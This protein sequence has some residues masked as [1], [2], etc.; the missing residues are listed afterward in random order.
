MKFISLSTYF[1]PNRF[2][3]PV[4]ENKGNFWNIKKFFVIQYLFIYS[5]LPHRHR[6]WYAVENIS[7]GIMIR[8][9]SSAT[10]V[11][12][13]HRSIESFNMGKNLMVLL[14]LQF[15]TAKL[16]TILHGA[17]A[18]SIRDAWNVPPPAFYLKL[19]PLWALGINLLHAYF[20]L[21]SGLIKSFALLF[22]SLRAS[23]F[24]D[25]VL[26][27]SCLGVISMQLAFLY[28]LVVGTSELIISHFSACL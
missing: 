9:D 11:H 24:L 12:T 6:Q 19:S 28:L 20:F 17:Q 22:T 18:T 14:N 4:Y 3:R 13:L 10:L 2:L 26:L 7:F 21:Q 16:N 15:Q 8:P 23:P 1:A 5:T 25:D 27:T